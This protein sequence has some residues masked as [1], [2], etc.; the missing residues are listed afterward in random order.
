MYYFFT[1]NHILFVSEVNY[2]FSLQ[3]PNEDVEMLLQNEA[4]AIQ[5][6]AKMALEGLAKD[7]EIQERWYNF[8]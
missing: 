3:D 4:L 8:Y 1:S 7:K 6:D 5:A 2:S